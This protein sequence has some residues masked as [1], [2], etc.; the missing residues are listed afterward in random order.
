[1]R[2]K[3]DSGI[4]IDESLDIALIPRDSSAPDTK[5]FQNS[6]IACSKLFNAMIKRTH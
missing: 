6:S 3:T 2:L 5:F 4:V 1:M